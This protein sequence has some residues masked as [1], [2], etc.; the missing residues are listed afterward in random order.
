MQIEI[1]EIDTPNGTKRISMRS[2]G[3]GAWVSVSNA[4]AKHIR[5]VH[6]RP[7]VWIKDSSEINSLITAAN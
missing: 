2:T 6:V 3:K 1:I 4:C 5:T 7:V